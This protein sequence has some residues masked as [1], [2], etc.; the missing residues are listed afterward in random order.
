MSVISV[1][2]ICGSDL[3]CGGDS[4]YKRSRSVGEVRV[5]VADT[6]LVEPAHMVDTFAAP[7]AERDTDPDAMAVEF[8]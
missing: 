4:I 7:E 5:V 8:A 2:V 3:L 6:A 1:N